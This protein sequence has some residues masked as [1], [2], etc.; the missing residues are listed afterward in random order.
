[1]LRHAVRIVATDVNDG[2]EILPDVCLLMKRALNRKNCIHERVMHLLC[3]SL[4]F[5]IRHSYV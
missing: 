5:H 3:P 1:M 2:S 4:S